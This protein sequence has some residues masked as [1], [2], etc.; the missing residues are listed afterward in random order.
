MNHQS[1][2]VLII[3]SAPDALRSRSW[4]K[5]AFS[6]VVAI[7]NAW[8]VR[9]DWDFLIHPDDFPSQKMPTSISDS[10]KIITSRDYV[11]IQNKYGGFVY[12]GGTMAFTAA[13]WA[14]GHLRPKVLA[15]VGCDMIY[16]ANGK[17]THFYGTGN[18]DPLRKD[19]TL[20]SLEAK[21]ARL[22]FHAHKQNCLCVNLTSLQESRL[23]FPK[24]D[25]SSLEN[26]NQPEV[27]K[28]LHD[29]Q[30]CFDQNH[31]SQAMSLEHELDYRF[32]SGRYWEH[33]HQISADKCSALDSLWLKGAC[34][35]KLEQ[36]RS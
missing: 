22:L 36:I 15:F 24:V 14:L 7:N 23:V 11:D 28:I 13:Y 3:G 2:I 32:S 10:Q 31:I 19:V 16:P 17:P 21:S 26:L 20:Q 1:D 33:L 6:H 8:Q 34:P 9:D 18:P 27:E 4:S 29:K 12:A 5:H 30:Q 25:I 35:G